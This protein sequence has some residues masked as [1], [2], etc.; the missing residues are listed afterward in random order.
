MRTYDLTG[1]TFGRLK[2]IGRNGKTKK[3]RNAVA[4]CL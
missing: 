4:L 3:R 2:V 1:Q